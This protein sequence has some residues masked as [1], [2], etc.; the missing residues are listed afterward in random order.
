MTWEEFKEDV[1]GLLTVDEKR[2]ALDTFKDKVYRAAAVKLQEYIPFYQQ[3]QLSVFQL[4]QTPPET[5]D[6]G[7]TTRV[8]LSE[9]GQIQEVFI[10]Y[11]AKDG[12]GE[13]VRPLERFPWNKRHSLF[14]GCI[15]ELG[16]VVMISPNRDLFV[17]PKLEEGEKIEIYWHGI[18]RSFQDT[19]VLPWDTEA[20]ECAA[21]YV[22]AKI[23]REVDK[24][25]NLYQSYLQTFQKERQE[26]YLRNKSR[27][28]LVRK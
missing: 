14:T 4:N 12:C 6:Q 5:E 17:Y 10:R 15:G 23:V 11:P 19:T 18:R 2:K 25:L 24:D 7:E 3:R 9:N 22:K 8:S 20:S 16:P 27:D 21:A 1:G 13:S 28:E 26:L